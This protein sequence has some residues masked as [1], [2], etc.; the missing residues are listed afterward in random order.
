VKPA[1]QI[2][3]GKPPDMSAR[4]LRSQH[5]LRLEI[6]KPQGSWI[7]AMNKIGTSQRLPFKTLARIVC[8][9]ASRHIR[10]H[11]NRRPHR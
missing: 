8:G 3:F 6:V 11:A 5:I 4:A 10:T 7:A 9:A 1:L 2:A